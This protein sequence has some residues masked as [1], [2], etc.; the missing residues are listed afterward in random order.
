MIC[1]QLFP[2]ASLVQY[3]LWWLILAGQRRE[4]SLCLGEKQDGHLKKETGSTKAIKYVNLC[5]QILPFF[6]RAR[7]QLGIC[8]IHYTCLFHSRKSVWYLDSHSCILKW[9]FNLKDILNAIHERKM[10]PND[11]LLPY[12]ENLVFINKH[13]LW[14]AET[15]YILK[16]V[17]IFEYLKIFE[18]SKFIWFKIQNV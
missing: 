16:M 5:E 10:L 4:C 12:D 1:P 9:L 3:S 8:W 17:K 13:F 14:I 15:I 7:T 18:H 2:R 6:D 11:P